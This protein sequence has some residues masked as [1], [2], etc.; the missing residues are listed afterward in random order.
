MSTDYGELD[1]REWYRDHDGIRATT[2]HEDDAIQYTIDLTDWLAQHGGTTI[3]STSDEAHGVTI[4]TA[5]A[6][7]S[8]MGG[9][10]TAFT[11]TIS[12]TNGWIKVTVTTADSQTLVVRR[13]FYAPNSAKIVN[14]YRWNS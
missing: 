6:A 13:R 3:S 14:D 5:S 7:A 4:D 9:S 11:V 10:N 2:K 12:G 1:R 8:G